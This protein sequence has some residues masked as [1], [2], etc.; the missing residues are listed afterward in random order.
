MRDKKRC[1]PEF[2]FYDKA[3][4]R[5]YL[6]EQAEKGWMLE[7]MSFGWVFRKIEPGKIHFSVTYFPEKSVFEA[8]GSERQRIFWDFCEHA[9][10]KLA[11]TNEQ[12]QIFYNE[13]PEPVPIET[14]AVMEVEKIHQSAK[15]SFLTTYVLLLISIL[16]QVGIN[17]DRLHKDPLGTLADN[18]ILFL[19]AGSALLALYV[20]RE[21][22]RYI[23]WYQK[24][25]K[26]AE[27]EGRFAAAK[28]IGGLWRK[29]PYFA[30][31][32]IIL[33]MVFLS[34]SQILRVFLVVLALVFLYVVLAGSVLSFMKRR[35]GGAA[36]NRL[37]FI[38]IT[39]LF[40]VALLHV[41][42]MM[43]AKGNLIS[44]REPARTYEFNGRTYKAYQDE[45]PLTVG[46][47]WQGEYDDKS[48]NFYSYELT[49]KESPILARMEAWQ[50]PR[51][52][53]GN[54]PGMRYTVTKIK[55]PCLYDWCLGAVKENYSYSREYNGKPTYFELR[56]EDAAFPG[57]DEAYRVYWDNE[58]E[59]EYVV[60][61]G[62]VIVEINTE[63][64]L[65]EE[66]M[67]IVGEKL[68]GK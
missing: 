66:Q 44:P 33:G 53:A 29:V 54:L 4:I 42:F 36:L 24:A 26:A 61:Y 9:G 45:L 62:D 15:K 18:S 34:S 31:F 65:T 28:G 37:T 2:S 6:E 14:D 48:R 60:C 16:L 63:W 38:G 43:A 22:I 55:I 12:M 20:L 11:A 50:V 5:R 23:C 27:T 49:E 58:A 25:K 56:E 3:G 46:D 51:R 64:E 52:D 47:L 10:W 21:I 67:G 59:K 39:V 8:E 57:A 17:L 40:F 68:G 41:M 19:I 32:C 7:K 30:G 13:N 1:I 35:G